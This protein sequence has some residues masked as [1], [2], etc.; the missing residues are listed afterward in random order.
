[1]GS[2]S[3]PILTAPQGTQVQNMIQAY[4]DGRQPYCCPS[5]PST[6][7]SGPIVYEEQQTL[8]TSS[9]L[10][11]PYSSQPTTKQTPP[12]VV[13]SG[14]PSDHRKGDQEYQIH[15][16]AVAGAIGVIPNR[17]VRDTARL[18]HRVLQQQEHRPSSQAPTP[19]EALPTLLNNPKSSS[20]N[21]ALASASA[22]TDTIVMSA[23]PKVAVEDIL[24]MPVS[25]GMTALHVAARMLVWVQYVGDDD[26]HQPWNMRFVANVV[27]RQLAQ[28][29]SRLQNVPYPCTTNTAA[30]NWWRWLVQQA[31]QTDQARRNLV[32]KRDSGG[33]SVFDTFWATWAHPTPSTAGAGR[34]VT[35]YGTRPAPPPP[36]FVAR[37]PAALDQVLAS[38]RHLNLL[39][40]CIQRQRQASIQNITFAM[41][42]TIP[43]AV[44][45]VARFWWALTILL[46][47]ARG[48][49]VQSSAN[50]RESKVASTPTVLP[51]VPFLASTGSCPER[52]AR[53]VV[54]LFPE[55]LSYI[56]PDTGATVLHLWAAAPNPIHEERDG[57]LIPLLRTCPALAAVKDK[58]GRL[59]IHV[60]LH[61]NKAMSDVRAL[62]EHAPH[63]VHV[64]DPLKPTLPL[65]VL[66]TLTARKQKMNTLRAL[67]RRNPAVSLAEWLDATRDTETLQ[68][69]LQCQ[70]LSSIYDVLRTFPQALQWK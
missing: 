39:Q 69:T 65:V 62:W 50:A 12:A 41:D 19:L 70:L 58:Q 22:S 17:S 5:N 2:L 20:L 7:A 32:R 51:I 23:G 30:R 44:Y 63:T 1:M 55:Q 4:I 3:P 52:L 13:R 28:R 15:Q 24:W 43:D 25:C 36:P 48:E 29:Q 59:P 45:I 66:V 16:I 67:E 11:P 47:G 18:V 46:D 34:T 57:M 14:I 42:E 38:P 8:S 54:C 35:D 21:E 64:P 60:A 10:A 31:S 49:N 6:A 53:L 61:W 27:E 9:T 68:G 33:D 56:V 37:F 26:A 40:I